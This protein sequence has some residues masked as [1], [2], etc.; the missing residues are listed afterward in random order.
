MSIK[1]KSLIGLPVITV[2]DGRN[3]NTIKDIVYDGATN[4]VT[5]FV[6]DE[7]GWFNAAKIIL[8]QD[9]KSIGKDAVIIQDET[10]IVI[11]DHRV[12]ASVAMTANNDNFLDTNEVVT[13]SGTK[14]GK[15]VDIYFDEATGKLEA[16][17]VSEGF[18]KDITSGTKKIEID[19]IITVGKENLIVE[20]ITQKNLDDQGQKQGLNKVVEDVKVTSVSVASQAGEKLQEVTEIVKDKTDQVIHSEPVQNTLHKTQEVA[21]NVKDKVAETYTNTKQNIDSGEAEKSMKDNWNIAK[22]KVVEVAAA[23]KDKVSTTATTAKDKIVDVSQSA[24]SNVQSTTT[25]LSD[26]MM[27]DRIKNTVGKIIVND[28]IIYG[29]DNRIIGSRGDVITPAMVEI[30]KH[31]NVL[32]R[33]L[34]SAKY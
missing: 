13:Q 23:T 10:K 25:Q 11:A 15:V 21:G 17:E 20:D 18:I 4:Q 12:D 8:I 9:I 34:K 3:I 27:Q 7:K 19:E 14:L 28:E 16:I 5:A 31:N 1:A 32:E 2:V 22:D 33:L 6:V 30:A 24:T 26:Q 29:M